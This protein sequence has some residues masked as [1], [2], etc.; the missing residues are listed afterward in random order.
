MER[1]PDL[2]DRVSEWQDLSAFATG[3]GPG[4]QLALVRGRRRQG[5]S[6]M[7]RRLAEAAGGFYFQAV[8]E[9]RSQALASLGSALGEHLEVPGGRL[10]LENWDAAVGALSELPSKT[11]PTLVVLDEFP[12]LLAHSPELP[13]VLQRA[14][15][16]SRDGVAP[17]RLVLCG[18]ALSAMAGLLD[19]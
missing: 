9:E 12:Y 3:P 14:I 17:L 16:R 13:S 10:A 8:E 6:F 2:F 19:R 11:S 1:P 5:K 15:D 4:I 7:L 18:S